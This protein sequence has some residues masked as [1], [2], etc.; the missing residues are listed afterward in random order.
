MRPNRLASTKPSG[1]RRA[2]YR[3]ASAFTTASKST[4]AGC[5]KIWLLQGQSYK[6][7]PTR[8]S[9]P[10]RVRR[11]KAWPT[12]ARLPRSKKSLGAHTHCPCSHVC[13]RRII[14]SATPA[15]KALRSQSELSQLQREIIVYLNFIR[16]AVAPLMQA[17]ASGCARRML[18]IPRTAA[19]QG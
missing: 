13:T 2:L 5:F 15:I 1:I 17:V 12:A 4:G 19:R 18:G 6:P 11:D 14:L 3:L 9:W 7:R 8:R 10:L 16:S